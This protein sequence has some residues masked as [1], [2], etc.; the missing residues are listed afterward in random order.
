MRETLGDRPGRRG[1]AGVVITSRL[2]GSVDLG[3]GQEVLKLPA[4]ADRNDR[5]AVGKSDHDHRRAIW[6]ET[7]DRAFGAKQLADLAARGREHLVRAGS[8]RHQGRDS[9]QRGLLLNKLVEA[10]IWLAPGT[11]HDTASIAVC[12][13]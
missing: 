5:D 3:G 11:V 6:L 8:M 2:A 9:P 4:S 7:S 10:R 12:V 1:V 13:V